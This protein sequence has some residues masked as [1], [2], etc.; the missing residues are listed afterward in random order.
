M[1]SLISY[2]ALSKRSSGNHAESAVVTVDFNL[3]YSAVSFAGNV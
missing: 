1:L 2:A 3:R